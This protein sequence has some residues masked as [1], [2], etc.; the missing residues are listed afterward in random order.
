MKSILIVEDDYFL[1]KIAC[2]ILQTANYGV[3][4]CQEGS[5]VLELV[6]G[7][8]IDLVLLDLTFDVGPSGLEILQNL[9]NHYS[10]QELPILIFSGRNEEILQKVFSE[11][12]NDYIVKP[13]EKQELLTFVAKHI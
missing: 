10:L 4:W 6:K 12:A 9:R 2:L 3:E 7:K 8:D 11:G 1:G 13:F 5:E